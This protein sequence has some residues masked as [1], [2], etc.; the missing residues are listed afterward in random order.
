VRAFECIVTVWDE[1]YRVKVYQK[2]KTVWIAVGEYRGQ[3]IEVK[4]R[5]DTQAVA[6]WQD[7]ARY[8]GG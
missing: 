7:S 5:T 8:R 3:T 6:R 1:Q 4:G 2:S